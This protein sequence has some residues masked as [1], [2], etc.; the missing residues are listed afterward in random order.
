MIST[1]NPSP[2]ATVSRLAPS[3][4]GALHLGNART[5]L[6]AWLSARAQGGKVI[7][8]GEDLET[9]GKPGVVERMLDDL[10][11]LGLDWD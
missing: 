2:K 11:W 3:P 8:R 4:T 1:G 10:L 7:L 6:W 5:F 9:K